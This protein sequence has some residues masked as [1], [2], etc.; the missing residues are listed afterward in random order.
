MSF[1]TD[2]AIETKEM[3]DES[4]GNKGEIPGVS[5]DVDHYS[6]TIKVTRI[7]VMDEVESRIMEKDEGDYITIE[8]DNIVGAEMSPQEIAKAH[9]WQIVLMDYNDSSTSV[10]TSDGKGSG[11]SSGASDTKDTSEAAGSPDQTASGGASV[12]STVPIAKTG[13]GNVIIYQLMLRNP[14]FRSRLQTLIRP[15]WKLPSGKEPKRFPPS[16]RPAVT[17]SST[18]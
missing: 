15:S 16:F 17:A 11:N 13:S 5:V 1:R 3:Y 7:C 8:A 6:N 18:I 2:L 12:D 10:L 9:G 4:Q 14:T